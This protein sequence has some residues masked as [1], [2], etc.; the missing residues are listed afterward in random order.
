[1]C[2]RGITVVLKGCDRDVTLVFKYI[3]RC[4]MCVRE[5]LQRCHRGVTRLSHCVI[6]MLEEVEGCYRVV[7]GV[8]D[9]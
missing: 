1:M 8:L 6:F 9:S 5:V 3:A 4:D 7:V 2:Y